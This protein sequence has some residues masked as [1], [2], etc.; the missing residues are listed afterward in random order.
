MEYNIPNKISN[1]EAIFER[2]NFI[3]LQLNLSQEQLALKLNISQP[4]VSKYLKT[5]IPPADV[6]LRLANF[7]QTTVEWILTGEKKYFYQ[8]GNSI[9]SDQQNEYIDF[10]LQLAAKIS[11]L[12]AK[13]KKLISQMVDLL[14][15][16]SK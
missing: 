11:K 12:P 14:L 13:S 8:R 1:N 15:S 4:A 10:D 16:Q 6:L 2:I 9:V 7:G 3:R 5:R